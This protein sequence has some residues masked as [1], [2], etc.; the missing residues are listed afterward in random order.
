MVISQREL[1]DKLAWGDSLKEQEIG[2]VDF[3][4]YCFK[5][6]INFSGAIFTRR[7]VF[8]K[9]QFLKG[10]DFSGAHFM[11][12]SGV[13]FRQA[14]FLGSAGANFKKARFSGDAGANFC[15]A[16]F[17]G[18][19]SAC[20]IM[21]QFTARGKA[22]FSQVRFEC[23]GG[24]N[25]SEAKFTGEGGAYFNKAQFSGEGGAD[26][27][28]TEFSGEGGADFWG[29]QFSG[30][31]GAY[32]FFTQFSGKRGADFWGAQFTGEEGVNFSEAKFSGE[33]G[34]H[35]NGALF[36]GRGGAD[37]SKTQFT[38]DG[39][40]DFSEVR[41]AGEGIV[42][43]Y[44]TEFPKNRLI[45]FID[46]EMDRPEN[47]RFLNIDN[48]GDTSFLNMDI[49]NVVFE[50]VTFRAVGNSFGSREI[51]ADEVWSEFATDTKKRVHDR[52]YFRT[53]EILYR[54]LKLNF[55]AKRDYE[56][57]GNFHYGEMEMRR[58][59][60][61]P[62]Y[63]YVSLISLYKILTGYGQRWFNGVTSFAVLILLF[64]WINWFG[65]EPKVPIVDSSQEA[66]TAE[67][68]SGLPTSLCRQELS[69]CS[70]VDWKDAVLF[71]FQTMTLQR[72]EDFRPKPDLWLGRTLIAL[73]FL[74]GPALI[75]LTILAV[76]REF[77]R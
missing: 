23:K 25:F 29:A 30:K 58:K 77:R 28:L 4:G 45:R 75:A 66:S 68:P 50:N 18:P 17:A 74:I 33:A 69:R 36:S 27:I 51:L 73:Q 60:L 48:L 47:V 57:A 6:P 8:Q 13:N 46:V 63:R 34:V 44:S 2:D 15:E 64:S 21:A 72:S 16:R 26:F 12:K 39:G 49:E 61:N 3:S 31:R 55:E 14:Q 37:F 62:F 10:V 32:F 20:F 5:E 52:D 76:R 24:A 59:Q 56:R 70:G 35:F 1:L 11:S 65:I 22:D 43:F 41:F 67:Q 19:G 71:T 42:K 53:V 9:V 40:A 54:K 7:A 38:G